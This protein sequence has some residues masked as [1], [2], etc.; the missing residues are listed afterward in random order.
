MRRLTYKDAGV[1]I[2]AGQRAVDLIRQAVQQTHNEQVLE[3]LADFGGMFALGSEYQDPVLVAGTDGVG[4]KLKIAFALDKHDT[5]GQDLV[6]MCVDDIVCQGAVPLLFL[7]YL[8]TGELKP[9][10]VAEIVGGVAAACELAGC[11]LLG[12]ETAELPGFYAEGEYDMAGFTVGVVERDQIID[13]SAVAA[14]D[15]VVGVASSG[16]HSNGYSL[17]RKVLLEVEGLSLKEHIPELGRTLGEELLEPTIIY[18]PA[19]VALFQAGLR[20]RGLAHITGGGVP[21]NLE[22]IIPEKLSAVVDR[23]ALRP[24]PIFGLVQRLGNVPAEEMYRTFNMGVGM[25]L[26]VAPENGEKSIEHLSAAGLS[27]QVIGEVRSSGPEE[28]RVILK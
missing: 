22:R 4:T 11:V 26:V 7:D 8:A 17:V 16:L 3:G 13:G 19:L 14:G 15:V 9:Q 27:S 1:D 20:P 25:V 6:A 24:Q 23:S 21:G 5:V 2:E 12:G 18:A 10:T 28:P